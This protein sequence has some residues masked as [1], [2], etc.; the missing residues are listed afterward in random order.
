MISYTDELGWIDAQAGEM[1]ALVT[2][3]ANVN[4]YS[5]N[6]SGLDTLAS[7]VKRVFAGLGGV[8]EEQSLPPERVVNAIGEVDEIPLGKLMLIRKRSEAPLRVLLGIHMDTVYPPDHPFQHVKHRN[9]TLI[10]PGVTD[11]KGGL[12]IM[13]KA[14]EALERSP[15]AA[16]IG[17]DVFINPDEEIGS[18]G[19][20]PRLAELAEGHAVGLV[21]EPALPHGRLVSERKGTGR[22]SVVIHGRA[23]HAGRAPGEGRHAINELVRFIASINGLQDDRDG[24]LVNTGRV[25]G[26]GA[27]NVVPDLAVGHFAVRV[28]S[29]ADQAMV[30]DSLAGLVR[31][32]NARD[33]FAAELHGTFLKPPKILDRATL[34]LLE[35]LR[36]CGDRL[37]QSVTWEPSSGAS[38]GNTLAAAGLPT[39]DSLGPCGGAIH[40]ADEFMEIKSLTERAKLVALFLIRLAAGEVEAPTG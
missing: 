12:V 17:W 5:H 34:H 8:V 19:S 14:L 29:A 26:G 6:L 21:F 16:N 38:D 33:G 32:L 40:S 37:G 15:A 18:P 35:S 24:I 3:W 27:V 2:E 31:D 7:S 20:A 11:A 28:S 10:G 4:S 1:R 9:G 13:L 22:F 30:E 39:A 23:A 25:E 36:A